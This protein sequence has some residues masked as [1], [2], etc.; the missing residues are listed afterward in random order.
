MVLGQGELFLLVLDVG[1]NQG[2][3]S[4]YRDIFPR[5]EEAPGFGGPSIV[6]STPTKESPLG[7]P[8][9]MDVKKE[10]I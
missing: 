3:S 4:V 2:K 5:N 6:E 9:I 1:R 8:G 10:V 7:I